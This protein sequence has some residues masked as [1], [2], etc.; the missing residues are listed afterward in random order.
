MK[1]SILYGIVTWC[2]M[3]IIVFFRFLKKRGNRLFLFLI[4]PLLLYLTT[5]RNFVIEERE[6]QR[7]GDDFF[8]PFLLPDF[9]NVTFFPLKWITAL[10]NITPGLDWYNVCIENNSYIEKNGKKMTA[11]ELGEKGGKLSLFIY[12]LARNVRLKELSDFIKSKNHKQN[13]SES[14]EWYLELQA[15]PNEKS[16]IE[17]FSETEGFVFMNMMLYTPYGDSLPITEEDSKFSETIGDITLSPV[18]NNSKIIIKS[19]WEAFIVKGIIFLFLM[20]GIFLLVIEIKKYL[21]NKN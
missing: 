3:K 11:E 4:I 8:S 20:D 21:F 12:P 17:L 18:A 1:K 9:N 13:E 10:T 14:I 7:G 5:Y 15:K 16:C 6:I 19:S 2:K